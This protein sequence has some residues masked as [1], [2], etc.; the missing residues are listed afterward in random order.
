[1]G[2]DVKILADSKGPSGSRMTTF[3]LTYPRFVHS[4]LMTH[5]VLSRNAASSRAIPGEK[6]I[7]RVE[8]D[9]AM[10]VY[11][12][13][14]QSGMQARSELDE[15]SKEEASRIWLAARDD[16]VKH[17]RALLALGAHKQIV[18]RI[19][20][21]WMYITVIASGTEWDNFFAL[22]THPDAQ[23][24]I[25]LLADLMVASYFTHAPVDLAE[26]D[27]HL[28]LLQPG[29]EDLPLEEKKMLATARSA[30]VSYLTHAGVRDPSADRKLHDQ[31]VESGHWSPF[32][33][34]A[35]AMSTSEFFGNLRGFKPYRKEFAN[36]NRTGF[37]PPSSE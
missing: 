25:K 7:A 22:R 13:K 14:N 33:H 3:E 26:G 23:P 27:W 17:A 34:V 32:E 19:I 5:R 9:P 12:G 4:E 2:Y 28:P 24:E 37:Q 1:M 8:G 21:P 11:W 35:K 20:E 30:R 36:E 15:N 6:L 29:E 10:P 31:L 18:N 16:A